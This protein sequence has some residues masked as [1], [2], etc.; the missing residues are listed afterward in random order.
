MKQQKESLKEI[1]YRD[2]KEKIIFF[3]ISVNDFL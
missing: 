3:Q 1:I 2:L